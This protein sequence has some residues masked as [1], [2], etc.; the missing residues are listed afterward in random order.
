V[1][2]IAAEALASL[3][4]AMSSLL[5]PPPSPGLTP[6]LMVTPVKITPAGIGGFVG[7]HPD[8]QGEVLGRRVVARVTVDIPADTAAALDARVTQVTQGV[9]SAA[10]A[11]LAQLGI[12]KLSLFELG[13]RP[14]LPATGPAITPR[15]DVSFDVLFEFL[16]PPDEPAGVIQSI[17]LDIE[18]SFASEPVTVMDGAFEAN[19]LANFDVFDDPAAVSGAPSSWSF[20]PVLEAVLQTSAIQGGPAGSGPEKPGTYLVLRTTPARP[21]LGNL[22]V[23]ASMDTVPAGGIG[24]VFRFVDINNFYYV[25]LD[26]QSGFRRMGKKVGGNFAALQEG[27]LDGSAGFTP[28]TLLRLRLVAEGSVFRLVL[29]GETVLEGSDN[30]LSAGRVGFM[31][32]N[33]TGA[34]FFDFTLLRL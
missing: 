3:T 30:E 1:D 24:F 34:R 7:I 18:S 29:D 27:G 4:T 23:A 15:R 12:L 21:V 20:D 11:E 5:P 16:K 10:R 32:R 6:N 13:P 19:P 17:P 25:L 8:P 26:S 22:S 9:L 33:C 31:V 28:N 2:A 14:V